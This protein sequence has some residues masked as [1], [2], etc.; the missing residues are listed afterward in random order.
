M[1]KLSLLFCCMAIC[2]LQINAQETS[3]N[4]QETSRKFRFG[5]R[6]A[7]QLSWIK[8][9]Y[10][11]IPANE[12]YENG[13][14]SVGFSWGPQAEI[15]FSEQFSLQ[16]GVDVNYST[17]KVRG[18]ITT[19]NTVQTLN[20]TY[21]MRFIEIP[22]G[23]KARTKEIGYMRYFFNIGLSAGFRYRANTEFATSVN[24]TSNITVLNSNSNAFVNAFRGAYFLGGGLEYALS[25]NTALVGGL[26][27][28]NGITNLLKSQN[29][30]NVAN[31]NLA[32]E[33]AILN[34]LQLNVGILF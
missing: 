15:L 10:K 23:I 33:R 12:S 34:Y 24:N 2:A 27:F 13:G 16:T 3:R 30:T 4:A 5:L 17:G 1:K 7:P 8:A 28:S 21:K 14:V 32:D 31:T 25:G 9:D 19:L 6:A 29:S 26:T 22:I 11:N 18:T 20:Q